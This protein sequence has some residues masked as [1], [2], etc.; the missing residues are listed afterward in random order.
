MHRPLELRDW[1]PDA[2]FAEVAARRGL[3]VEELRKRTRYVARES[4]QYATH[5]PFEHARDLNF[6][7]QELTHLEQ[8]NFCLGLLETIQPAENTVKLFEKLVEAQLNVRGLPENRYHRERVFGL[9]T[10]TFIL[11]I[12]ALIY[13]TSEHVELTGAARWT[14]GTVG[15]GLLIISLI[16]WKRSSLSKS[17]LLTKAAKYR[18]R[19]RIETANDLLLEGLASEGLD[20]ESLYEI[21]ST[22]EAAPGIDAFDRYAAVATYLEKTRPKARATKAYRK[23]FVESIAHSTD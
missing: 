12:G 7:E 8:C 4:I 14:V 6:T 10:L 11:S 9:A 22:L 18:L 17:L 5:I 1:A 3:T 2:L 19:G 23:S 20:N 21:R 13:L 15:I 16:C